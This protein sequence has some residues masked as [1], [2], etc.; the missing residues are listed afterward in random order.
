MMQN[1]KFIVGPNSGKN[2]IAFKIGN[3]DNYL[4]EFIA[5]LESSG[6]YIGQRERLCTVVKYYLLENYREKDAEPSL[7]CPAEVLVLLL[8][9]DNFQAW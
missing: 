5:F 3:S 9:T 8:S 4:W 7:H 6:M 2:Y 1:S